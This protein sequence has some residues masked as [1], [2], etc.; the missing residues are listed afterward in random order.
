MTTTVEL[1]CPTGFRRL[2]SKLIMQGER[3]RVTGG[4]L[5]EFACADCRKE[6]KEQGTACRLVLH[7]FDLA[8]ELV[9]SLV[10]E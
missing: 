1:R 5:L 2:F 10:L 3:P 9:E 8:G 6:L 7:R 4:N